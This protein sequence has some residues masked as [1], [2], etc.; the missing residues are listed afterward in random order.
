MS[1][2][3]LPT[4]LSLAASAS[5]IAIFGGNQPNF[6]SLGPWTP[7]QYGLPAVTVL[8]IPA[9]A[10]NTTGQPA[11]TEINYV[12]DAVF[13][14]LHKRSVRKTSHPVLTGA[15]ISDHSYIVAAQVTFEIGMSDCMASYQDGVWVGA[16]TKSISAWQII[17]SILQNKTLLTLTTRLDTYQNMLI[18]DAIAPDDNKTSHALRATI[19]MEE[20]LS[21]SVVSIA[22]QS[23]I[24]QTTGNTP[25]GVT[26]ATTPNPTQVS[27]FQVIP[28]QTDA[29]TGPVVPGMLYTAVPGS[30]DYSSNSIYQVRTGTSSGAP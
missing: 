15:N 8:T 23:A 29:A 3:L 25:N 6:I 18:M 20:L 1:G 21:A 19:I 9:Q 13:R 11:S 24:P 22:S 28:G 26:Q 30:G 5:E 2:I 10:S 27:Q 7:P 14:I 16:S 12:F 17:K 4:V